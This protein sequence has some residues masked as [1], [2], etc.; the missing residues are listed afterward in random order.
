MRVLRAARMTDC[1][2]SDLVPQQKWKWIR[3]HNISLARYMGRT[4]GGGLCK[5]RGEPG[6][7]N[8]GVHTPCWGRVTGRGQ[9]PS[10]LT[11]R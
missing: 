7:E 4:R 10:P 3:I 1:G 2:I 6:A 9:G 11:G 5:L 8:S